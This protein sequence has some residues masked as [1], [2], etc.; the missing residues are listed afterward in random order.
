MLVNVLDAA[1]IVTCDTEARRL[2]MRKVR[3]QYG[4]LTVVQQQQQQQ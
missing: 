4:A 1:G 2:Y 3:L